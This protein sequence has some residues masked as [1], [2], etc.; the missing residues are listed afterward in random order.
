M[1]SFRV[2][3]KICLMLIFGSVL[4]LELSLELRLTLLA[5]SVF[6]ISLFPNESTGHFGIV[7]RDKKYDRHQ[8]Y[9]RLE[10]FTINIVFS[11]NQILSISHFTLNL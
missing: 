9:E 1:V 2:N 10:V 4:G 11:P 5:N 7:L 8:L 6:L 3:I